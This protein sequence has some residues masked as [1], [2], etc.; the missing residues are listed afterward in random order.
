M[1]SAVPIEPPLHDRRLNARQRVPPTVGRLCPTIHNFPSADCRC[2]PAARS[3]H[4]PTT[5]ASHPIRPPVLSIPARNLSNVSKGDRRSR[6]AAS[7]IDTPRALVL[8]GRLVDYNVACT[9]TPPRPPTPQNNHQ[10]A[11]SRPPPHVRMNNPS[12]VRMGMKAATF[13]RL[14]QPV[15]LSVEGLGEQQQQMISD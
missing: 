9:M 1:S 8:S 12:S 15:R 2:G 5:D 7:T 4:A 13:L 3:T 6:N 11:P 14:G 10:T